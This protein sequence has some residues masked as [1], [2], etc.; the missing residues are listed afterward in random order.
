[1]RILCHLGGD[2]VEKNVTG[3]QIKHKAAALNG[4]LHE[5]NDIH[6]SFYTWLR[7]VDWWVEIGVNERRI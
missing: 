5:V 2:V 6:S 1:M 7:T 4:Q 3:V